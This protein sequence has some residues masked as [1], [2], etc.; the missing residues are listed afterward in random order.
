[1]A[2]K[3]YRK[4]PVVVE[5]VQWHGPATLDNVN[6]LAAT[7]DVDRSLFGVGNLGKGGGLYIEAMEGQEFVKPGSFIIK[8]VK[9]EIYPCDEEIFH[10]T[11]EEA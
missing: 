11:Y 3:K 2:M 10:L 1:M 8:G 5:A 7:L 6:K 9:G 4:K